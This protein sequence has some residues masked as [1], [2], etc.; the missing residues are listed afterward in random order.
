MSILKKDSLFSF[1]VFL[2]LNSWTGLVRGSQSESQVE[3][4]IQGHHISGLNFEI[5]FDLS[6]DFIQSPTAVMIDKFI[7]QYH[8]AF[9]P[10][11]EH[12]EYFLQ[13][14]YQEMKKNIWL[15]LIFSSG[16]FL[17]GLRVIFSL[18]GS[19]FKSKVLFF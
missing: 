1:L 17:I 3:Q 14:L 12:L 16:L 6:L 10:I 15:S 8:T 13:P 19:C 18:L 4:Q 2:I 9:L 11:C 5:M 7:Q